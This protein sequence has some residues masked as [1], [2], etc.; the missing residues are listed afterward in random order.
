[1]L[2][3]YK[4]PGT[5]HMWV[6]RRPEPCAALRSWTQESGPSPT[7]TH[8]HVLTH[9]NFFNP[10]NFLLTAL[11][12]ATLHSK[13]ASP[14]VAGACYHYCS[15]RGPPLSLARSFELQ[16]EIRKTSK[17]NDI[18]IR[19]TSK[20]MTNWFSIFFRGTIYSKI[21]HTFALGLISN[22]TIAITVS[23]LKKQKQNQ[24]ITG[25]AIRQKLHVLW[26]K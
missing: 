1:M 23:L 11:S 5:P 9:K 10:Q 7:P 17:K 13:T 6:D 14:T 16:L 12:P 21:F 26:P 4:I 24:K 18:K 15:W 20:R 22:P 25:S 19:K 8:P 2:T 3:I